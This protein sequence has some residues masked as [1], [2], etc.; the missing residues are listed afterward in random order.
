MW[1]ELKQTGTSLAVS[2]LHNHQLSEWMNV[3]EG[4]CPVSAHRSYPHGSQKGTAQTLLAVAAE[5]ST[6]VIKLQCQLVLPFLNLSFSGTA[7]EMILFR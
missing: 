1:F 7:Q 5:Y 3:K 2:H 4:E 6:G